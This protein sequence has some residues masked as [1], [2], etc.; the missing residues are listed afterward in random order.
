[1]NSGLAVQEALLGETYDAVRRR[2]YVAL[3]LPSFDETKRIVEMFGDVVDGYK[4]GLQLFYAGGPRVLDLLTKLGKRVFLDVKLHDIP[5]TVA[6]AITSLCQAY[7]IE[8]VNVHASGGLRMMEAARQAVEK[9]T[10]RPL[11]IGVTVLTSMASD[12]VRQIGVV[13]E[14]EDQVRRLAQLTHRAGLDGVV[15]S[16]AEL[17]MLRTELPA[18]FVT[19]IPGTRMAGGATHDQRRS[20][21]P[22]IAMKNGADQLVLGR[23][24]TEQSDMF[25]ALQMV[26]DDMLQGMEQV[27]KM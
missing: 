24:V 6:G 19:V 15:A 7:P 8:M 16:A 11:L 1:M 13:E 9:T 4:V 2:S 27:P 10:H 25:T 17:G 5:N 3:D 14:P 18:S 12:D 21:T 20:M 23:A 26:W 22:G